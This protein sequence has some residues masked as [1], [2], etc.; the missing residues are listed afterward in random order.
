MTIDNAGDG[1]KELQIKDDD[2][3]TRSL[4]TGKA[5]IDDGKATWNQ[6]VD[7]LLAKKGKFIA[8]RGAGSINGMD[9]A[10]IDHLLEQELIPRVQQSV[11]A[12]ETVTIFYDGDTDSPEKPDIGHVAGRLLDVFGNNQKGVIFLAAQKRSWYY[13]SQEGGYLTN[14]HGQNFLT[15]VFE[16]GIYPG[17]HNEFTQDRRL[18][19]SDDYEQW[20]IGASGQIAESQLHDYNNKVPDD[21][22]RRVTLFRI[23]N[24]PKLDDEIRTRLQ[25]AQVESDL[26][27]VEKFQGQLKQREHIY[28]VHWDNMGMPIVDR[29]Q[30]PKLDLRL[31][32]PK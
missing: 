24:N 6:L 29:V 28:G 23:R 26:T 30:F 17:D 32:P 3:I 12:G 4:L 20:Y 1:P 15:Y 19:E 16:D 25:D 22:K 18:V 5:M 10:E 14:A 31:E 27:K 8:L 11:D 9:P 7:Q 13:P 21:Q 2:L